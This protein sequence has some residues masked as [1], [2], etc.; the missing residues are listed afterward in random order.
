MWASYGEAHRMC[1]RHLYRHNWACAALSR[2]ARN[3]RLFALSN[4]WPRRAAFRASPSLIA[5]SISVSISDELLNGNLRVPRA[6]SGVGSSV[7]RYSA[8]SCARSSGEAYG[9]HGV[10]FLSFFTREW[11]GSP[12]PW[13]LSFFLSFFLVFRSAVGV[14]SPALAAAAAAVLR[15]SLMRLDTFS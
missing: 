1:D 5:S 11:R 12:F 2:A 9:R 3:S 14:S 10:I 6:A 7:G 15:S 4:S 8:R 13:F